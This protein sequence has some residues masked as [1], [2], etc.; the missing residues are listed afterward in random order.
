MAT[1]LDG[2]LFATHGVNAESGMEVERAMVPAAEG[3]DVIGRI[4][5]A[6]TPWLHV[7]GIERTWPSTD[8]TAAPFARENT[9]H[10]RPPGGARERG[11]MDGGRPPSSNPGSGT[12][13]PSVDHV[14]HRP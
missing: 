1:I 7:R 10:Q 3:H 5:P 4:R 8:E 11:P 14:S 9:R 6:E 13:A 2:K 12:G